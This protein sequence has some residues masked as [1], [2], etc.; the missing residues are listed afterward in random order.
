[1]NTPD[2]R[3]TVLTDWL[4]IPQAVVSEAT[5]DLELAKRLE[6]R[7]PQ[8]LIIRATHLLPLGTVEVE[9]AASAQ[10]MQHAVRK[11]REEI[12]S[13]SSR[14]S[15]NLSIQRIRGKLINGVSAKGRR[16]P[17]LPLESIDAAEFA[18]L[19]LEGLDAVDPRTG[20]IA[21]Y[22]LLIDGQELLGSYGESHPVCTRT[23]EIRSSTK[24]A[25]PISDRELRSW[26]EQRVSELT[27]CGEASSGDADWEAAKRQFPGRITRNRIRRVREQFA[28][29]VWKTQGRRAPN[30]AE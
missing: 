5:G 3:G 24:P 26:Y 19:A 6:E 11:L 2:S 8:L 29:A 1:V 30:T 15:Y 27:A 17:N 10:V 23:A 25:A 4:N 7:D 18:Y 20:N 14:R 22:D 21:W 13:Q 16:A 28:P 12:E 9:P